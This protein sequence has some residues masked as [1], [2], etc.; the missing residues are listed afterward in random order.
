MRRLIVG[1]LAL[2]GTFSIV[3]ATPHASAASRAPH[4]ATT[5]SLAT[6]FPTANQYPAG[7][8][9]LPVQQYAQPSQLFTRANATLAARYHF[10]TGAMQTAFGH[11]TVVTITIARFRDRLGAGRF[12]TAIQFDVI[13]DG[14]QKSGAV[15][16]LGSGGARYESG[17]CASCGPGAPTLVQV[18]FARGPIFVQ[19]GTQPSNQGLARRL[20]TVIDT[21]L[22]R[23]HV[24]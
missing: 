18:F 13:H 6:Y 3:I 14:K 19:V 10:V 22:K 21:K 11:N 15:R 16:G 5:Q 24:R 12:R 23:A 1:S 20:G 8:K 17:G 9:P 4:A 2:S 7:Y